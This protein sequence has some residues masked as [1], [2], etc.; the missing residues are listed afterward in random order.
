MEHKLIVSN[1]TKQYGRKT[2]LD[3]VSFSVYSGEIVGLVGEN[4]SGKTQLMKSIIGLIKPQKGQVSYDGKI[5]GKDFRF[6]PDNGFVIENPAFFDELTGFENLKLLASINNKIG[7]D[8]IENW[9]K[10]VGLENDGKPVEEYSLGML[11]RLGIAQALMEDPQVIILDEFTNSLDDE[12]VKL[13]YDLLLSEKKKGKIIIISS[14][15]K[16]DIITLCDRVYRMKDGRINEE[17]N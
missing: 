11:Q 9:I 16:D 17:Q 2:V 15:R 8:D 6:L 4:G 10:T 7:D 3:N 5:V 14:H 13:V 1:V 12:G